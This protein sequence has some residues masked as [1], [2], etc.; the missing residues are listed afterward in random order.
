MRSESRGKGDGEAAGRKNWVG[1]A[2]LV[3]F[4][5]HLGERNLLGAGVGGIHGKEQLVESCRRAR[6]RGNGESC[7]FTP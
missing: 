6:E 1:S 3:I 7:A 4:K 2:Q 5:P